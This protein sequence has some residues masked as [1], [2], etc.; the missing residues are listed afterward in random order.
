MG[1]KMESLN[2]MKLVRR[3]RQQNHERN[4][5]F[6]QNAATPAFIMFKSYYDVGMWAMDRQIEQL[7]K[8]AEKERIEEMQQAVIANVSKE[9]S[10]ES[11][12]VA[13]E[14]AKEIEKALKIKTK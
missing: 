7:E 4:N 12:K 11:G 5:A 1:K 13:M 2:R 14:I 9:L 3:V 6:V 8:E 10:N